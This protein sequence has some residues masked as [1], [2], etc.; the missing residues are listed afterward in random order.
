M[1]ECEIK[2]WKYDSK[3]SLQPI[4]IDIDIY[5]KYRHI[6]PEFIAFD[7][8]FYRF[9]FIRDI[10]EWMWTIS[11]AQFVHSDNDGDGLG[12]LVW[13]WI[14][15]MKNHNPKEPNPM[16]ENRIL[17]K[18]HCRQCLFPFESSPSEWSNL[19]TRYL[20]R[21]TSSTQRSD[22]EERRIWRAECVVRIFLWNLP[23]QS[24]NSNRRRIVFHG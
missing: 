2:M 21:I 5:I 12:N 11:E 14:L 8:L 1:N 6:W 24:T 9:I 20:R 15:I 4:D 16:T 23:F 19:N 18:C 17:D 13:N 3:T 22:F 10:I 7:F